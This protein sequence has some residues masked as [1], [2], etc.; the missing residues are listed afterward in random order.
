MTY[1][2]R[3]TFGEFHRLIEAVAGDVPG[4]ERAAA[5]LELSDELRREAWGELG[6]VTRALQ[7]DEA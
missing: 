2:A 5:F 7:E 1:G 6:R 4:H 3:F